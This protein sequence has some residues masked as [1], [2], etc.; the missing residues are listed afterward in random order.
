MSAEELL[1][2]FAVALL[3]VS[4]DG[5]ILAWNR[6]A[7]ALLGYTSAEAVGA[8]LFELIVPDPVGDDLAARMWSLA[9]GESATYESVRRRRDGA[10]VDVE[11]TMRA[12]PD[13]GGSVSSFAIALRDVGEARRRR[14]ADQAAEADEI[15]G[16]IY[17]IAHDLKAPLRGITGFAEALVEDHAGELSEGARDYVVRVRRN[18]ERLGAMIEALLLLAAATRAVLR[19]ERLDLVAVA[20]EVFARH[21]VA[22]PKRA[23]ELVAPAHLWATMDPR[24][25]RTLVEQLIDNA[26]KFTGPVAQARIEIGAQDLD[27][28]ET[29]FVRDNGVGFPMDYAGKL[30]KPFQR[31]HAANEFP[32]AGIGLAIARRIVHRHGGRIRVDA[33][34]RV[35]T[36]IL[37]TV[38][39]PRGPET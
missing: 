1:D 29:F 14:A 4:T 37:F 24:L 36:T 21:G 33:A 6:A 18:A 19:L 22:Q 9:A 30:F 38:P 3:S 7:E 39:V 35:G 10:L 20:R 11:V 34:E 8:S 25:A 31:L 23:V 17:A 12:V 5:R 28:V 15:D 13:D 16:V 2:R 26:W 32:G 27:G